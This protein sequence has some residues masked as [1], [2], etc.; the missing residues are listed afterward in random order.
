MKRFAVAICC[1]C[2]SAL[3]ASLSV[4]PTSV[5][6]NVPAGTSPAA[7]PIEL[8]NAQPG[9]IDWDSVANVGW[10]SLNPTG[11]TC[12]DDETEVSLVYHTDAMPVG[13]HTGSVTFMSE[14]VTN[15]PVDVQVI[16]TLE[17]ASRVIAHD[18]PTLEVYV[19]YQSAAGTSTYFDVWNAAVGPAVSNLEYNLYEETAWLDIPVTL[20]TSITGQHVRHTLIL[21]NTLGMAEGVYTSSV[22]INVEEPSSNDPQEFDVLLNVHRPPELSVTNELLVTTTQGLD[23]VAFLTIQNTGGGTLD[24]EVESTRSWLSLGEGPWNPQLQSGS[25]TCIFECASFPAG[26]NDAHIMVSTAGLG[27]EPTCVDVTLVLEPATYVIAV[28]GPPGGTFPAGSGI[29]TQQMEVWNAGADVSLSYWPDSK[30]WWMPDIIPWGSNAGAAHVVHDVLLNIDWLGEGSHTGTI[31]LGSEGALNTPFEVDVPVNVSAILGVNPTSIALST[32]A[33]TNPA[34]T[35]LEIWNEGSANQIPFSVVWEGDWFSVS[36]TNNWTL[37]GVTNTCT[38]TF[39]SNLVAGIYNGTIRVRGAHFEQQVPVTLAVDTP[40]TPFGERIVFG[41]NLDGDGDIWMIRPDGSDLRKL[42]DMRDNQ[43]SP[44]VSPDGTKVLFFDSQPNSRY[45]VVDLYTGQETQLGMLQQ[46]CWKHDSSGWFDVVT[47]PMGFSRIEEH[48]ADGS[49]ATVFAE[50]GELSIWDTHP[51][52][53]GLYYQ[54][55]P[56]Q[57]VNTEIRVLDPALSQSY[58]VRAQDGTFRSQGMVD[59]E[60]NRLCYAWTESQYGGYR[61][62]RLMQI[63][64]TTETTLSH[65][66]TNNYYAPSFA[67]D[68]S[69]VVAVRQCYAASKQWLCILQSD[70]GGESSILEQPNAANLTTPHW[71]M[72]LDANPLLGLSTN[73]FRDAFIVGA[74]NPVEHELT[75]QNLG[76]SFLS[77]TLTENVN[78]L[79]LDPTAGTST[80]DQ[81]TVT[82]S[83]QPQALAVG[84]H[85]GLVTVAANGTNADQQVTVVVDVFEPAPIIMTIAQVSAGAESNGSMIESSIPVWNGGGRSMTF[86]LDATAGWLS[87]LDDTGESSGEVDTMIMRCDPTGLA[88]GRHTATVT[89]SNELGDT[90]QLQVW[91]DVSGVNPFPPEMWLSTT[92]LVNTVP[93]YQNATQQSFRVSNP[94]GSELLYHTATTSDWLRLLPQ[95]SATNQAQCRWGG[96]TNTLYVEYFTTN[97]NEGLHE[98]DIDVISDV[99][100]QTV[101]VS[102]TVAP[103]EHYQLTITPY[104]G[105][106]VTVDPAASPSNTYVHMTDVTLTAIPTN[107]YLFTRW[108]GDVADGSVSQTTVRI[109]E[110][111]SV[112]AQ[113]KHVTMFTGYVTNNVTGNPIANATVSFG[114]GPGSIQTTTSGTGFYAIYPADMTAR[115]WVYHPSYG[116]I[117]FK[118]VALTP[119]AVNRY[120]IGLE[121]RPLSML[122]AAQRPG[123][124]LVDIGYA[125][126]GETNETIDVALAISDDWS[127]TWSVSLNSLGGDLGSVS[128]GYPRR[129][130]WD[131]GTD[132]PLKTRY[133]MC[134]RLTA[135]GQQLVSPP[136]SLETRFSP[137]ATL[138]AYADNNRNEQYDPGEQLPGSEVYIG[139]RVPSQYKG[140]T[141]A[142]GLL[143]YTNK[144][145]RDSVLFMRKAFRETTAAKA[146]HHV[147]D[148]IRYAAWLDSDVGGT[149][150]S[151]WDGVWD[152]RQ[153]D[154]TLILQAQRGEII[155]IKLPHLLVE[156]YLV[157]DCPD[158]SETLKE[159]L[160]TALAYA[161]RYLYKISYGQM[162]FGKIYVDLGAPYH[163]GADCLMRASTTRSSAFVGAMGDSDPERPINMSTAELHATD[164]W[165]ITNNWAH[166]LVHEFGHY[167]LSFYDEYR[168]IMMDTPWRVMRENTY[169]NRYPKYFGFM[170]SHTRTEQMSA[171]NDYLPSM[172]DYEP[173]EKVEG[174]LGWKAWYITIQQLQRH[175][176][177]WEYLEGRWEKTLS[178]VNVE[179]VSPPDGWLK[180]ASNGVPTS[181]DREATERIPAP[182]HTCWVKIN[183]AE[184]AD[185][186]LSPVPGGAGAATAGGAPHVVRVLRRG[187][188]VQNAAVAV[189]QTTG[190]RFRHLGR[191]RPDGTV[192]WFGAI[193]ENSIVTA[194]HQGDRGV[195]PLPGYADF[196]IT[197]ELDAGAPGIA[198]THTLATNTL[199]LIMTC[200]VDDTNMTLRLTSNLALVTNPTVVAYGDDVWT[201]SVAMVEVASNLV[202]QGAFAWTNGA[203]GFVDI[204]CE[205]TDSQTLD[206]LDSYHVIPVNTN[207]MLAQNS[208]TPGTAL[209]EYD[210]FGV[211]YEA[212][213]PVLYPAGCA[214]P[215]NQVGP[216]VFF[217]LANG[218]Q[219]TASNI[220]SLGLLYDDSD[221]AGLDES[222][223]GLY[224]WNTN[225]NAWQS[226]SNY[227]AIAANSVGA[228]ISNSGP[229][230]LLAE[231]SAD[232]TAPSSIIDLSSATG[233]QPWHIDLAWT[234]PG[235]DGTNGTATAYVLRYDTAPITASNWAAAGDCEL[236]IVPQPAGARET[237][238]LQMQ[239]LGT[240][241]Y[242]GIKAQDEAGNLS[243]TCNVTVARSGVDDA[244]GDGISD[245]WMNSA[246][247]GRAEPMGLFDD[248]DLDGLTTW[249]EY[250]LRTDPSVWDTDG[251]GIG[252]GYEHQHG[253]DPLSTADADGDGDGDTL[254]NTEEYG[255]GTDPTKPDT[256]G[257]GMRD[258]W[259][260][261]RGLDPLTTAPDFGAGHNPDLDPFDNWG[262]YVADTDP[263]NAA[264]YFMVDA[265]SNDVQGITIEFYSSAARNYQVQRNNTLTNE[266]S[267][268][269]LGSSF[270]GLDDWTLVTDTN[271]TM[272][273]YYRVRVSL[274]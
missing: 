219:M 238:S 268:L 234:A 55:E 127:N 162:K 241:Y 31:V 204:S 110:D 270:T 247:E 58:Q 254:S 83:V 188:P 126:K 52:D 22:S 120:D 272:H 93:R 69:N 172:S 68:G 62:I 145:W 170:D 10:L 165:N 231:T 229:F 75:V 136:F 273:G 113:F 114:T 243:A 124:L 263:T 210:T 108:F 21:T 18:P 167:G 133:G 73:G 111:T 158:D 71:C 32:A 244:D 197:I 177:C 77:Y 86:Y 146:G 65:V 201:S 264:S 60:G 74:T 215:T 50:Q 159:N 258:D 225:Q 203:S 198:A 217:A 271:Q 103:P 85:T 84:V 130:V 94:G 40:L 169:S 131:A 175:K 226:H 199:G 178:G 66:S 116:K 195:H 9:D 157:I 216:A 117:Y 245:Q 194:Y 185:P 34:P 212:N 259:E 14:D 54:R 218:L 253:L 200:D 221:V 160:W 92:S 233:D 205:S 181:I 6:T 230:V 190:Q 232:T 44:R 88:P 228:V 99:D 76:N 261:A 25:V 38:V 53:A 274:P 139:G 26:T 79:S 107:L 109:E 80:G 265:I 222:T 59:A 189:K 171:N 227:F 164:P 70:G 140:E 150:E 251:D 208:I 78:W 104:A 51:T 134:A 138:R 121:P 91:F 192:P 48:A 252:D 24:Y 123:T 39:A 237:V 28:Q 262:E 223:L 23:A 57:G 255:Y 3:A 149:D 12:D 180:E 35:T 43:T 182:Y 266:G 82:L 211:V 36:P 193:A 214:C 30:A 63:G 101:A 269:P 168:C 246:N 64:A 4:T 11:G 16:V 187:V 46:P 128:P 129:I 106:T 161:S 156:W 45:T 42:L 100:T 176:P 152:S 102:V 72:M 137:G 125:L 256:D 19:P 183:D 20:G 119:N 61:G 33:G 95:S 236:T 207:T 235:D 98:T 154:E 151:D 147:V 186:R 209:Q 15:P 105:G 5:S 148:N 166:T 81:H 1:L 47:E 196:P 89:V 27:A 179:L 67:P 8:W 213:G 153:F 90:S 37:E 191:T 112:M 122:T 141:D 155:D 143:Q 56:L 118:P 239:R 17:P 184:W 142:N 202:W 240:E 250:A 206:T 7:R 257:D 132:F 248:V 174:L 29:V 41:A 135:K 2:S 87:F 249:D 49:V 96:Q 242:F 267:W 97:L 260:L 220:A 115:Y 173:D 13:S 163:K 144:V 224:V